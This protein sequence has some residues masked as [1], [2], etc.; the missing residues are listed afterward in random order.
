M[1]DSDDAEKEVCP[2]CGG[3]GEHDASGWPCMVCDGRGVVEPEP[4][5]ARITGDKD[6]SVQSRAPTQERLQ[7]FAKA[8]E[9]GFDF[10][11][12]KHLDALMCCD[13]WM[14]GCQGS[15]VGQYLAHQ[16]RE[17]LAQENPVEGA[18][19]GEGLLGRIV[20]LERDNELL[21][22]ALSH[23]QGEQL[24]LMNERHTRTSERDWQ[25]IESAPKD[26]TEID[27]W[28]GGEFPRRVTDV[29]WREPT[30]SE[31]W[32][33]GGD[34]IETPEATWHDAFGPLGRSEQP[35]HW[36]PSPAPP[37]RGDHRKD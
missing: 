15:T 27:V 30:D 24:R 21:R 20:E 10:N 35:T 1:T 36:K 19:Y 34:T 2:Y 33:H 13:G 8:L 5:S 9:T 7:S 14:C 25:G 31:W 17:E 16:L 3:C 6:R 28:V 4:P 37:E 23:A 29:Q 22:R 32:V 12:V 26:G 18:P 11:V